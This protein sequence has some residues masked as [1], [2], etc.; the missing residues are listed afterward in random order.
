MTAP[1][2]QPLAPEV[3]KAHLHGVLAFPI[4]PY[5]ADG[6]VDLAAVRQNAEWLAG[7]GV[8]ALVA[9]SGTGELFALTPDECA[10]IVAA[11][12]GAVAGRVPVIAG[13]GFGPRVA[14]ELARRAER[15]GADGILVLPPY[16]GRPDDQGLLAYYQAV[17]GATRLGIMPYARDAALFT[18]PLLARGAV[19]RR[20]Q[21][22]PRRRPPLPA[23]ARA[24]HRPARHGAAG[25][26]G[27]RRRRSRRALLCGRGDRLYV[28]A[29][30]LLAGGLGRALPPGKRRRFRRSPPPPRAGGPPLLRPA[31]AAT[32]LRGGG[33][34]SGDG[35][36]RPPRRPT[37]PA[38]RPPLPGRPGRPARHHRAA[39]DSD[40]G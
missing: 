27:R 26:A 31:A 29:R 32:R 8:C 11:T 30:L 36:A 16:Y 20:L 18:P 21:G 38:P 2:H 3:L 15:A 40:A 12:V 25:L 9:P 37:P 10:D 19:A 35:S 24:R 5:A 33:D 17:A 14:A 34:E 7:S 23:A 13:V 6:M 39:A 1:T 28:V 4:T 22:R